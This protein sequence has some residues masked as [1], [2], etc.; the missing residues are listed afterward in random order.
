M[1]AVLPS[2]PTLHNADSFGNAGQSLN[3]SV[4]MSLEDINRE[5]L[6]ATLEFTDN[7]KA[8]AAKILE[9]SRRTIQRKAK[10]YGLCDEENDV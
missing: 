4:G 1:H 8:K 6:R 7:N 2:A 3:V 10:E 9:I 5:V